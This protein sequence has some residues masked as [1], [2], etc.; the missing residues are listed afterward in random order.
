VT[1]PGRAETKTEWGVYHKFGAV[2]MDAKDGSLLTKCTP[3]TARWIARLL[4]KAAEEAE[5][6]GPS[7]P[8]APHGP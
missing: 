8:E 2:H 1:W 5:Q 6:Y 4:V 3:E 7:K